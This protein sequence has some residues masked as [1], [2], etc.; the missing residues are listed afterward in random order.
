LPNK[1]DTDTF[2]KDLLKLC[3][4]LNIT[5]QRTHLELSSSNF[6]DQ[7]QLTLKFVG[8]R[9]A[10]DIVLEKLKNGN[11][12]IHLKTLHRGKEETHI[13]LSIFS[14]SHM[15]DAGLCSSF[16]TKVWVWPFSQKIRKLYRELKVICDKQQEHL[17]NIRLTEKIRRKLRQ[18]KIGVDII[19]HLRRIEKLDK[20]RINGS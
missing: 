5:V 15:I 6:Y 19:H 13:N 17:E 12:I 9:K 1:L 18:L 10:T 16:K 20:K 3:G 11:R 14:I 4:E 7:A 8:D 2:F